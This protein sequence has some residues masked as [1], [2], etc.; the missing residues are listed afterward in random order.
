M[1][2]CISKKKAAKEGKLKGNCGKHLRRLLVPWVILA[3]DP[4]V[5]RFSRL[6]GRFLSKFWQTF[7]ARLKFAKRYA[8]LQS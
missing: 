7:P 3:D 2:S 8:W 1:L 6:D 4:L 5:D